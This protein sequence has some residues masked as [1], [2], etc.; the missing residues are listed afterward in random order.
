MTNL[1]PTYGTLRSMVP[2]KR[3]LLYPSHPSIL[4]FEMHVFWEEQGAAAGPTAKAVNGFTKVYSS[5]WTEEAL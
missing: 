2:S 3:H 5:P 1:D 4:S